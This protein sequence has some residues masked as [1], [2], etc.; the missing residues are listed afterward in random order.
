MWVSPIDIEAALTAHAAVR[1]GRSVVA[2][3]DATA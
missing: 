1:R 2:Y 3:D